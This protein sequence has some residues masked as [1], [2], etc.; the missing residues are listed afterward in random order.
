MNKGAFKFFALSLGLLLGASNA[1]AGVAVYTSESAWVAATAAYTV[2]TEDFST[3]PQGTLSGTT[4][5]G[6]FDISVTNSQNAINSQQFDGYVDLNSTLSFGLSAS[7][8]GFAG[9]WTSTA[10]TTGL[11]FIVNGVTIDAGDAFNDGV[12]TG[13]LGF[14][15]TDLA[16]T[17]VGFGLTLGA[18]TQDSEAFS[19]DDAQLAS[20]SAT[21]SVPE[22]SS[23]YLLAFGLLGLLGAARRKS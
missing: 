2:A 15:D 13:F 22:A 21:P 8:F 19:L 1:F 16:I 7:T 20:L 4:D 6:L 14:V 10:D 18:G 5:I 11:T 12:G 23:L 9:Y 17:N 3:S